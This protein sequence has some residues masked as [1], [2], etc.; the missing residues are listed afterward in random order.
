MR[1][2]T[3]FFLG[4]EPAKLTQTNLDYALNNSP[5]GMGV[6]AL[7]SFLN[8]WRFVTRCALF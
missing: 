4:G 7:F 3:N 5:L 1:V 6:V 8:R 2:L